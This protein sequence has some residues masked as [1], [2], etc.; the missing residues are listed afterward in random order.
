MGDIRREIR[1]AGKN[2]LNA[3]KHMVKR[4]HQPLQLN[5]NGLRVKTHI[6]VFRRN[7][8]NPAADAANRFM[9]FVDGEQHNKNDHHANQRSR[10]NQLIFQ[11]VNIVKMEVYR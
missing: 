2:I 4:E 5:R 1:L 7:I 8:L 10:H 3:F 9:A 11:I 6:E